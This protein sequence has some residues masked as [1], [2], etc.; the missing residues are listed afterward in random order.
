MA[1]H[2]CGPGDERDQGTC[3][4]RPRDSGESVS[5]NREVLDDQPASA[6]PTV[7]TKP[8]GGM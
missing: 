6:S 1:D 8:E 4:P 2:S 3:P 7:Y 5:G